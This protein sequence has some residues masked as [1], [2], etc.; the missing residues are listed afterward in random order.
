MLRTNT[1][2]LLADF[3]A[4]VRKPEDLRGVSTGDT[5]PRKRGDPQLAEGGDYSVTTS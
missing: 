2:H 3:A 5:L 1:G 4:S